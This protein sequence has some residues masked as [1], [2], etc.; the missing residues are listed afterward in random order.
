MTTAMSTIART[1]MASAAR[2]PRFAD[3]PD[4]VHRN[5]LANLEVRRHAGKGSIEPHI[6]YAPTWSTERAQAIAACDAFRRSNCCP[7][8]TRDL[9]S[10]RDPDSDDESGH[11]SYLFHE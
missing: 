6:A 9:P 1:A 7:I 4:E 8:P 5:Q 3:G 10:Q 11:R 2:P